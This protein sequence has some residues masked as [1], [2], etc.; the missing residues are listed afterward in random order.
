MEKEKYI[1][2]LRGEGKTW[3]HIAPLFSHRF[4]TR[5]RPES[6]RKD[7]RILRQ[8]QGGQSEQPEKE[9]RLVSYQGEK[10]Q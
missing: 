7:S 8:S 3:A 4:S 1:K 10:P 2:K 9:V 5:A 6:V